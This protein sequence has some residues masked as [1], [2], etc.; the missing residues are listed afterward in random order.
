[1]SSAKADGN[2]ATIRWNRAAP[3]LRISINIL[4]FQLSFYCPVITYGKRPLQNRHDSS[5]Y[6]L[7]PGDTVQ[8]IKTSLYWLTAPRWVPCV[9]F[10]HGRQRGTVPHVILPWFSSTSFISCSTR[11]EVLGSPRGRVDGYQVH[12]SKPG[13]Y[14]LFVD[15]HSFII[16]GI[17]PASA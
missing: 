4:F 3:S 6:P 14:F 13:C 1:M 15:F 11:R 9:L 2:L 12:M 5:H 17:S 10:R 8:S 7:F 16:H